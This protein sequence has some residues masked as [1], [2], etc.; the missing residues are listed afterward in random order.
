MS[1]P[2]FALTT[3]SGGRRLLLAGFGALLILMLAAGVDALLVLRKVRASDAQ[4]RDAYFTRSRSLEG[5]RAGIY[6]SAIVLRDFLLAR[7][8]EAARAQEQQWTSMRER[9]DSALATSAAA[10]NDQEQPRVR[11]LQT[12]LAA[13]WKL[14]DLAAETNR[15]DPDAWSSTYFSGEMLR[16]RNAM[17]DLIDQIDQLSARDL[18]ASDAT[19]NSTFDALRVRLIVMLVATFGVGMFVAGFTIARTLRLEAELQHR[20]EE[21][22]RART[23]LQELSARLLSA[24]E[25][26]RRAISRELHDEVGQSLS[27]LLM[28]AGNAAATV[29]LGSQEL[30]KHVE[31]IKKLAEA[32]VAVIRNMTLLLRPSMLDDFGLV[33]AL[34]WQAREVSKR[35][36]MRVH[37]SAEESAGE[38]S[39]ELKTCIYRV[40]Q[41][42]LHNCARHAHARAVKVVVRQELSRII[43]SVEDDGQGFDARRVRGLGL[44][45][46]EE[47]VNHLGGAFEID[48]RPGAGTKV[49]VEL[50][51]AS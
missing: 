35:T 33:P 1:S 51:L 17:I 27:A 45:G 16:R 30:R 43:L 34:E 37:V 31:S 6:E 14:M 46:M 44:V 28:E 42:A 39:D 49:A 24:Q 50:P 18:A 48:S 23:E 47:R 4:V 40:V 21:G 7:D 20:Y 10:L 29:P 36:G 41:E 19:L 11:N 8:P 22:Q 3:F 15:W 2:P 25:E 12:Q 38:L 9:T 32:S 5:V 13:Y 26:E